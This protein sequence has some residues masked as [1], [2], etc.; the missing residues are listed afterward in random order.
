MQTRS[1][2][3]RREGRTIVFVPTMGFLHEGHLSLLNQGRPLGD[4]LVLSI[5][6]NPTQFGQG[7]DLDAY[8]QDL[9]NDLQLAREAG[10]DAVFTPAREG[11]YGKHYQ[12]YVSLEQLP[13]H[14]CGISRPVHFRGVATVVAKLFNIVKPHIAI[15]GEKDFQQLAVIRQL[16]R[17]LNYDIEIRGGAIVRE[18]DGLAMSS[19]NAYLTSAQRPV[20]RCLYESLQKAENLVKKG[21]RRAEAIIDAVRSHIESHPG[22]EVD[23]VAVCDPETLEDTARIDGQVLLAI[24]VR[25]G[26]CRLIDNMVLTP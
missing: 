14:L 15:F 11:I 12:T 16:V 5:F 26:K 21:D 19:R 17:D 4:D 10:V 2:R 6:V 1:D 23:Y 8:P 20:A 18:P 3:L 25:L 24:A 13:N 9:E 22:T 7:E